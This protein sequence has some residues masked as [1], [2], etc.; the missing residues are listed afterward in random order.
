GLAF[1]RSTP[2]A[3]LVRTVLRHAAS[4]SP[5]ALVGALRRYRSLLLHARD[6]LAGG[7]RV[8]RAEIR[9]FTG[10]AGDQLMMWELL[11]AVECEG[12]LEL[13]DL[14]RLDSLLLEAQRWAA[15]PDP[16]AERLRRLLDHGVST[17][18]F[19]ARRET[20]R[21]LRDRLRMRGIAWCTGDRAGLDGATLP[22]GTVLD[23]F[24][25][26]PGDESAARSGARHLIVTDVVAE[27][28]DLQRA[29]RVVHYDLPWT[30]MRMEQRD[31]RAL[32]LGSRHP[33]VQV[34]RF[35]LPTALERSLRIELALSRK[36]GLPAAAGL[37]PAGR[38]L[39]R[40]RAELAEALGSSLSR[41][42]T[43]VVPSGPPGVLAGFGLHAAGRSTEVRLGFAIGWLDQDGRWSEDEETVAARL[44]AAAAIEAESPA[45]PARLASALTALAPRVRARLRV[46]AER[47]WSAGDC[48]GAARAVAAGLQ[49]LIREAARRRDAPALHLLE[50]ALGFVAG[51]HTAGEGMLLERLVEVEG[52]ELARAAARLPPPTPRW[53]PV[54]ARLAGVLLFVPG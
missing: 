25:E 24:R 43:A 28:L 15:G 1:S 19:V 21:H 48:D 18:V 41:G 52:T 32:R 12:E 16:K 50:R 33:R 36:R 47:R 29:G 38:R 40:W 14:D 7:R 5:P 37:G 13:A 39:W 49:R 22:R 8:D 9:R 46:L 51:G 44:T 34:V 11:P 45:D 27:G 31:G 4:S 35:A 42:G 6:A 26:R 2:I 3:S 30:P 23:W 17:L 54:E 10:Q 53:G 20:V